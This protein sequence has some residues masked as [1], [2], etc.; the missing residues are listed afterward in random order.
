MDRMRRLR[1]ERKLQLEKERQEDPF[2]KKIANRMENANDSSKRSTTHRADKSIRAEKSIRADGSL[3]SKESLQINGLL[4]TNRSLEANGSLQSNGSRIAKSRQFW[5]G[6]DEGSRPKIQAQDLMQ[7]LANRRNRL[8]MKNRKIQASP[9]STCSSASDGQNTSE[10]DTKQIEEGSD[11]SKSDKIRK[12]GKTSERSSHSQGDGRGSR[13]SKQNDGISST[14]K[15]QRARKQENSRAINSNDMI[16]SQRNSRRISKQDNSITGQDRRSTVQEDQRS[17][18]QE[19]RRASKQES[20]RSS[21]HESKRS[22]KHEDRRSSTQGNRRD[23]FEEDRRPI[24][25]EDRRSSTQEHRRTSTQDSRRSSLEQVHDKSS[26]QH[27][28]IGNATKNGD[29]NTADIWSKHTS[30]DGRPYYYNS[31]TKKSQWKAPKHLQV[32]VLPVENDVNHMEDRMVVH[33]PE[34]GHCA[35]CTTRTGT[36]KCIECKVLFCNACTIQANQFDGSHV[37]VMRLVASPNCELCHASSAT[38]RCSECSIQLFCDECANFAHRKP[39]KHLHHRVPVMVHLESSQALTVFENAPKS[40][41]ENLPNSIKLAHRHLA[42]L[43]KA[44]ILSHSE[45]SQLTIMVSPTNSNI[46]HVLDQIASLDPNTIRNLL[47]N[48]VLDTCSI[49]H[50]TSLH[51]NVQNETCAHCLRKAATISTISSEQPSSSKSAN[52]SNFSNV[53]GLTYLNNELCN[54]CP[55]RKSISLW[56]DSDS[57]SDSDWSD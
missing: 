54:E 3:E 38:Q 22:S 56:S 49:C 13:S 33:E 41:I 26:K 19:H 40:T 51:L 16:S 29:K 32:P 34:G 23:S 46:A 8:E 36:Q 42:L 2:L 11:K 52:C 17:S 12:Y 15:E 4:Q 39:P 35:I 31:E 44:N 10:E 47:P 50:G 37:H 21:K 53:Q 48:V 25:Q 43:Q 30:P 18:T 24:T 20:K 1:M 5:N 27:V 45:I 55:S 28:T 14:R 7:Q 6:V 9:H 57:D